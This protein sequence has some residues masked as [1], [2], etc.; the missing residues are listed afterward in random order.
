M[1]TGKFE[2]TKLWESIALSL[3]QLCMR[4]VGDKDF[5]VLLLGEDIHLKVTSLSTDTEINVVGGTEYND[6]AEQLVLACLQKLSAGDLVAL[7]LKELNNEADVL[8]P[9]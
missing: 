6:L 9:A 7:H 4:D 1:E 2:I 8:K 5:G 3:L